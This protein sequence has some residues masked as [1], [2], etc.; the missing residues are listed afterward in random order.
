MLGGLIDS[1]L[2][3]FHIT[4]VMNTRVSTQFNTY[5]VQ[6]YSCSTYG[7]S[8]KHSGPF[9]PIL[10]HSRS[11]AQYTYGTSVKHTC[12]VQ[13]YMQLYISTRHRAYRTTYTAA[14]SNE[15]PLLQ[16][17]AVAVAATIA[18]QPGSPARP[19]MEETVRKDALLVLMMVAAPALTG[20]QQV[21]PWLNGTHPPPTTRRAVAQLARL[22]LCEGIHVPRPAPN[23]TTSV[24]CW[25]LHTTRPDDTPHE[26]LEFGNCYDMGAVVTTSAVSCDTTEAALASDQSIWVS[27]EALAY[28]IPPLA[29]GSSR[30]LIVTDPCA[31]FWDGVHCM[32]GAD[33]IADPDIPIMWQTPRFPTHLSRQCSENFDPSYLGVEIYGAPYDPSYDEP[34]SD[35]FAYNTWYD[36]GSG[37]CTWC[38]AEFQAVTRAAICDT[39]SGQ[40][41]GVIEQGSYEW[42]VFVLYVFVPVS[43]VAFT[44][45]VY[46][47]ASRDRR[48]YVDGVT[49]QRD[50][51]STIASSV[52]RS[53][54]LIKSV[55]PQLQLSFLVIS[56]SQVDWPYSIKFLRLWFGSWITLDVQTLAP[57]ACIR[58]L[59]KS[60]DAW[61]LQVFMA[62]SMALFMALFFTVVVVVVYTQIKGTPERSAHMNNFGWAV[63]FLLGPAVMSKVAAIIV[64]QGGIR[65]NNSEMVFP[66]ACM[67]VLVVLFPGY[68]VI[69]IGRKGEDGRRT[70]EF[71]AANS[72]MCGSYKVECW[73]WEIFYIEMRFAIALAF[74]LIQDSSI[75]IVL[76]FVMTT[77]VLL[78]HRKWQP[79]DECEDDAARWDSANKMATIGH[80]CGLALLCCGML[81]GLDLGTSGEFLLSLATIVVITAPA[82]LAFISIQQQV[83]RQARRQ[84]QQKEKEK[85][86]DEDAEAAVENPL[87]P[88]SGSANATPTV[89]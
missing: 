37:G 17:N 87:S 64:N 41:C 9:S 44:A 82:V 22:M 18:A 85:E 32:R 39:A 75:P 49:D 14:S 50:N 3:S 54:N 86:K 67:F 40:N 11:I 63:F 4:I 61:T 69:S 76:S 58:L 66:L 78:V 57:V 60:G 35:R 34:E 56:F 74:A 27:G 38:G 5:T 89:R 33:G 65:L 83:R 23:D 88:G 42:V 10:A 2:L 1:T 20:A 30:Y 62:I 43:F 80:S 51:V 77:I 21:V 8:V 7:T 59:G 81:S 15:P 72:W 70:P 84:E 31:G 47:V 71:A 29:W 73:W 68:G 25:G 55:C 26:E 6:L 19:G 36:D 52:A 28:G 45:L 13:L 12:T 24:P 46:W 16:R 53:S 48:D 79:F